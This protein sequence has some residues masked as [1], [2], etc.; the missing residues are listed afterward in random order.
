MP[1]SVIVILLPFPNTIT[2][3]EKHCSIK[4]MS[5]GFWASETLSSQKLVIDSIA[6]NFL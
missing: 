6:S 3:S 4:P 2:I 1:Q 5:S